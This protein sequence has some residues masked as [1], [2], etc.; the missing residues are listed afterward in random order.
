MN[1]N[2]EQAINEQIH[3]EFF[4]FYL[5]LAASAYF[6]AQHLDGFANWMRVQAHE[7]FG[8]ALKLYDYLNERGGTV[9]LLAIDS[10]QHEWPGPAAAFEAVVD[11]ERH[12][13]SRINRLLELANAENDHATA[14]LLHWYVTEQV[15]EE[16]TADRLYH[17]VKM[18]ESSPHGL[19]MIDR[20]LAG[21]P[22]PA[23]VT[24]ADAT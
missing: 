8:H 6:S 7:E 20:E 3:A 9:H 22:M 19:L 13:S 24:T 5:Y 21:R 16:A 4:S 1:R 14:V 15:E 17:Q 2:V 10:P 11:H 18:V 23:A 12:I